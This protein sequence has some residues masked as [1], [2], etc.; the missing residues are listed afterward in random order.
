MQ[1]LLEC[2]K[3]GAF[4]YEMDKVN[5]LVLVC[6]ENAVFWLDNQCVLFLNSTFDNGW[7]YLAAGTIPVSNDFPRALSMWHRISRVIFMYFCQDLSQLMNKLQ[8]MQNENRSKTTLSYPAFNFSNCNITIN[9]QLFIRKCSISTYWTKICYMYH[10][11]EK[12]QIDVISWLSVFVI[13]VTF[14]ILHRK[15]GYYYLNVIFECVFLS[16]LEWDVMY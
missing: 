14:I 12:L 15:L 6:N 2:C 1:V 10:S 8:I 7:L 13:N 16:C 5:K 11:S 3:P 4:Y 9:Y